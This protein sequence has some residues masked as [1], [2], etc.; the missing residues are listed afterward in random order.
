[1]ICHIAERVQ[2]RRGEYRAEIEALGRRAEVL[3]EAGSTIAMTRLLTGGGGRAFMK[4]HRAKSMAFSE[5]H[6]AGVL[7]A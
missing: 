4:R 1:M 7:T 5:Y 3:D 6:D 2:A